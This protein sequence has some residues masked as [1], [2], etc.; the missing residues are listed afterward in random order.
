MLK[1]TSYSTP[2]I[3]PTRDIKRKQ[4]AVDEQA[5][6]LTSLAESV[7][8]N[9]CKLLEIGTWCGDSSMVLGEVAR[10]H[11]GHLYCI[12][13]WKGNTGTELEQIATKQDI[14]SFFWERVLKNELADVIIPIRCKS[15]DVAGILAA[16]TFDMIYID[17]DHRFESVQRDIINFAPLVR[18]GGILCGDDCEGRL[19][20]FDQDFLDSGRDVDYYETVHCGVVMAVGAAFPVYS[21]DYNIWSVRRLEN[22][23]QQPIAYFPGIVRK[24]QFSPPLIETYSNYNFVRYGRFVYAIPQSLGPVDI[25]DENSRNLPELLSAKSRVELRKK[26]DERNSR[27]DSQIA[28]P[29]LVKSL[30]THNI[31]LFNSK[32][33]TIPKSLGE[34]HLERND[35]SGKS[36]VSISDSLEAAISAIKKR[37]LFG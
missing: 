9:G 24:R 11:N 6:V 22:G 12:D 37:T 34:L 27:N 15:E 17:G 8:H 25:S 33:Y 3:N 5:I 35:I 19:D 20:D 26:I 18:P 13:W 28:P 10:K 29:V 30:E 1:R 16:D 32:Y 2:S 4:M 31:V 21:I 14:F 23:W 36:G 7:A